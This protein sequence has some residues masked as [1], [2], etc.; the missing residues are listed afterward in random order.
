[1]GDF[2]KV[3]FWLLLLSFSCAAQVGLR[4]PAFVARLTPNPVPLVCDGSCPADGSP[5]LEQTGVSSSL[6]LIGDGSGNF[7]GQRWDGDGTAHCLCK[8]AFMA[9]SIN[10]DVSG[11]SYVVKIFALDGSS[12]FA[13]GTVLATS[14]AVAGTA[15][16]AGT[17]TYFTFS[18]F[19]MLPASGSYAIVPDTEDGSDD[20]VNNVNP[21]YNAA[22]SINGTYGVWT[23]GGVGDFCEG[24]DGDM[25]VRIYFQ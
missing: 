14:D 9:S 1:M 10:G 2:L 15:W 20:G 16:S 7:I 25:A 4:S 8:V 24:C 22:G 21:R 5:T 6:G 17:W 12:D 23:S 3:T 18:T 11:K 13:P 19:F